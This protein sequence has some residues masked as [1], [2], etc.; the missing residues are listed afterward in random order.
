MGI[1]HDQIERGA[2]RRLRATYERLVDLSKS[3]NRH[4]DRADW[5]MHCWA[6]ASIATRSDEIAG[7]IRE[8]AWAFEHRIVDLDD[9]DVPTELVEQALAELAKERQ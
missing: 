7:L 8:I 1:T 9:E 6:F 2:V 4:A 3:T 5:D